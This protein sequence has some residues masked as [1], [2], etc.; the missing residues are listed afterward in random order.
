MKRKYRRE[1]THVQVNEASVH[2]KPP[3]IVF[4]DLSSKYFSFSEINKTQNRNTITKSY[5]NR[6]NSVKI[7]ANK[8]PS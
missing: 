4:R 1:F 3:Q 6:S 8:F 7:R 2:K 5:Y